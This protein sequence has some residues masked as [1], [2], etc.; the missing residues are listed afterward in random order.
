[1]NQEG[2]LSKTTLCFQNQATESTM[3]GGSKRMETCSVVSSAGLKP[4]SCRVTPGQGKE[5][6]RGE[7]G[8]GKDLFCA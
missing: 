3:D 5:L 2:N 8:H 7:N 1:M 4:G 6:T